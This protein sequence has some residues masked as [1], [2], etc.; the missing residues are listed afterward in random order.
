MTKSFGMV[1][2]RYSRVQ[3][4][5]NIVTKKQRILIPKPYGVCIQVIVLRG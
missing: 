2:A 4:D 5:P 1:K 3:L